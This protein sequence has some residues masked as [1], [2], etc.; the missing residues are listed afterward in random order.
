MAK[1]TPKDIP[2]KTTQQ[3][4]MSYRDLKAERDK[5]RANVVD[6]YSVINQI[7]EKTHN[8]N[9]LEIWNKLHLA[10]E[11]KNTTTLTVK[12]VDFLLDFIMSVKWVNPEV[13]RTEKQ[14]RKT[15]EEIRENLIVWGY[16]KE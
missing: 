7:R 10:K 11:N 13:G 12:E 2:Q 8:R 6:F 14:I 1:P 15:F 9:F 16:V 4:P 3:M 5:Y